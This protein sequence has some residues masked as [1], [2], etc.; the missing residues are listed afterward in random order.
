[1]EFFRIFFKR[2]RVV[3]E[4]G[5]MEAVKCGDF[6]GFNFLKGDLRGRRRL[7]KQR[8]LFRGGFGAAHQVANQTP[9][10]CFSRTGEVD[11]Q[12]IKEQS[13]EASKIFKTS[14]SSIYS[15]V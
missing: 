4:L 9:L 5:L 11:R 14:A 10:I 12:K 8:S 13:S 2:E 7:I 15:K 1:M 3:E 6:I